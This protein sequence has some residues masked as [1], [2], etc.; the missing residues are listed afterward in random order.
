[1]SVLRNLG[2]GMRLILRWTMQI[3]AALVIVLALLVGVA[4]LLL[5]EAAAFREE[6]RAAVTRTTGFDID[7]ALLSAGVSLYGPELRLV[8]TV[9]NWPDGSELAAADE[10]AVSIDVLAWLTSGRIVPG[11]VYVEGSSVDVKVDADG[12]L[13]I[14]GHPLADFSRSDQ[15]PR[16]EDLPES[17]LHLS[18]IKFSF[19]N[20]QRDGPQIAGS[21]DDLEV[22]LDEMRLDVFARVDPGI[23]YG[24]AI[25]LEAQ[26]PLQLVTADPDAQFEESWDLRLNARD[27]RL[28]KWIELTEFREQPVIDSEGNAEIRVRFNG[29]LPVAVE[30][31]LELEQIRLARPGREPVAIDRVEGLLEWRQASGG[32]LVSGE[33]FRIV[34]G[35]LVWP[36]SEFHLRYSAGP[37]PD[38]HRYVAT[39]GFLRVEDLLPL[40]EAIAPN[41]LRESGFNG[42]VTGDL[43]DL[44]L[45]LVLLE[46]HVAEFEL[47]GEFTAAGYVSAS[48]DIEIAGFS[49]QVSADEGGG[50]LKINSR[51][52]RFGVSALFNNV[53]D[54]TE[55]DGLAIWRSG[56]EGYRVLADGIRLTTPHGGLTTSLELT[57]DADGGNPV[58]D[59]SGAAHLDDVVL[60]AFYLPKVV[61]EPVHVWLGAAL[62]GGQVPTADF[63]VQGPLDE[64]PYDHGEGVFTID[65]SFM[66]GVMEYSPGWPKIRDASGRLMFDGVSMRST[67]NLLSVSGVTIQDADVLIED[68]RTSIITMSGSGPLQLEGLLDFLQAS[69][70]S[71]KLGPVFAEM[72]ASGS[73][74][75]SM[76]LTLPIKNLDEWQLEGSLTMSDAEVGL[77]NIRQRIAGVNGTAT[78]SN[79]RITAGD[80]RGYFLDEPVTIEVEPVEDQNSP[81]SH[82]AMLT[83]SA[84]VEKVQE[85]LGLPV[86]K[87]LDGDL[88][89]QAQALF[90]GGKGGATPFRL[91]LRSDLIGAES[92]FPYPLNKSKEDPAGLQVELQFPV[93]GTAWVYGSINKGFS[94]AFEA[95]NDDEGWHMERGSIVRAMEIPALPEE[96]GITLTGAVDSLDIAAWTNLMSDGEDQFA[97]DEAGSWQQHFRRANLQIGELLAVGHRF[98]DV[99]ADIRFGGEAWDIRVDGPWT[100]GQ[101]QLPYDFTGRVPVILD[102]ER[103]LLI[104]PLEGDDED[105]LQL[106][107]RTLPE[108]Q[109][110]VADFAIGSLRLGALE[111]DIQ[112]AQGGLKSKLLRTESASFTGDYAYDWLVVDN[113]QLS[114]LHM[115][116]RSTDVEDTL[117][118]LGYSP[119]I[120]AEE[121]AVTADLLWEGGP[122]MAIVYESTGTIEL[123]IR[124]GSITEVDAGG[125]RILGLVSITTLPRRL[126]LDFKDLTDEGLPFDKLSGSFRIDFGN[127][128][129][130]DL[131]LEGSVADMG[132]VGR[133]GILAQ[134]YDQVA[135]IRP[136][137]SNL[138][139]VAGAF[140]A[141]PT[142]GIAT[143]LITQ[144]MKKPLSSIG[145]SYYTLEG[146]FDDPAIEKVD[147]DSLDIQRFADC[148]Q[149]LP[150][151]SPEEIAAIRDMIAD[152]EASS[153]A[154]TQPRSD[155]GD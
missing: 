116:L 78:I 143:L 22:Q 50:N 34:R 140:I 141:G 94:W 121:G 145:E 11:R 123:A 57:V 89:M 44:N 112:R 83:G 33:R 56:P 5:P 139:P 45:E 85:A 52:A 80:L 16:L 119:L 13:T 84:S 15:E 69:P 38:R 129:T 39:A 138:A 71:E 36:Q 7:F 14:Q 103:L 43:T 12:E 23:S 128:W 149:E 109:G 102:M 79:T 25:E 99:D 18:A 9:V 41:Q 122:G 106:D 73:A 132:L 32:W 66:D 120:A 59:L 124:N 148:E 70:I 1:M 150:T 27:F 40:A 100:A 20:E 127:A 126:S 146:S 29:R 118:K 64:F 65:V 105:D 86:L 46:Q 88:S 134:D 155:S 133:T 72:R 60:T 152:A 151:L 154:V 114:R 75:S 48:R 51:D 111:V 153:G 97:A 26:I 2:A 142:V 107:P 87:M 30:T 147:G 130:C 136:H 96:P 74:E 53:F 4:R 98:V 113:A 47:S 91:F 31:D 35:A 62:Q 144:I 21:I 8:D 110:R 54:I 49:G 92:G 28:D 135:A 77:N 90:P 95:T 42:S 3:A 58:I 101:L 55:L 17:L 61:P 108:V 131:G 24:R 137:V 82:R 125:G 10:V 76:A 19:R 93:T 37:E 63:R 67:S 68:M 115:K 6:I 117:V 104:E 81:F